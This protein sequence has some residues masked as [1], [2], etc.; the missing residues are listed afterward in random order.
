MLKQGWM[1]SLLVPA[2]SVLL[3]THDILQSA[4]VRA[5]EDGCHW[6]TSPG[7]LTDV[8]KN[9]TVL[10][11]GFS[12]LRHTYTPILQKLFIYK[13]EIMIRDLKWGSGCTEQR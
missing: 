4:S 3:C 1:V 13:Y 10:E 12:T 11:K 2:R 6:R 5:P 8:C 9:M 7:A